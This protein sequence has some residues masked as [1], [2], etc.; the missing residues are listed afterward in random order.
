MDLQYA[1]ENVASK[2]LG[3][4]SKQFVPKGAVVYDLMKDDKV[5]IV[6]D[7][8]LK[9]YLKTVDAVEVLSHG[10]CFEDN[11]VDLMYS[12]ERFT[13]HNFNANAMWNTKELK[14]FAVRD[15]LPGEE[16]TENYGEYNLP[17]NYDLAVKAILGESFLEHS[18][19]WV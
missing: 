4:I 19:N 8:E 3:I 11:F 9:A 10:F 12:D 16:I 17:R 15:I 7:S 18:K 14:S 2:G 6:K 1:I 13:N 5:I